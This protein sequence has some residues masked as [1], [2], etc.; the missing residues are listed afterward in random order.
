MRHATIKFGSSCV[1]PPKPT[2][3]ALVLTALL[4]GCLPTASRANVAGAIS[5]EL[6]MNAG[7]AS[8]VC[9]YAVQGLLA[10]VSDIDLASDFGGHGGQLEAAVSGRPMASPGVPAGERCDGRVSFEYYLTVTG[11]EHGAGGALAALVPPVQVLRRTTPPNPAVPRTARL[12][13]LTRGGLAIPLDGEHSV[14][15]DLAEGWD[16]V[17]ERGPYV[18]H[19]VSLAPGKELRLHA[20]AHSDLHDGQIFEVFAP[21]GRRVARF[22]LDDTNSERF[23]HVDPGGA[24]LDASTISDYFVVRTPGDYLVRFHS[25]AARYQLWLEIYPR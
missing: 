17:D 9:G 25:S 5:N 13:G 14:V 6:G 18:D 3:L 16:A 12:A 21:G 11:G 8:S 20:T 22:F 23:V 1:L 7:L 4:P 24:T 15:G 10:P 2:A 19:L